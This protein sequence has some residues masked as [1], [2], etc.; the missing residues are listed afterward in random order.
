MIDNNDLKLG[1]LSG[2]KSVILFATERTGSWPVYQILLR[3]YSQKEP[4][5]GLGEFFALGGPS[6]ENRNGQ[7]RVLERRSLTSPEEI[8][9]IWGGGA[10]WPVSI[11]N[12]I[13]Q[14]RLNMLK[15]GNSRY[16]LKVFP[17]HCFPW[18]FES[19]EWICLERRNLFSQ[20]LSY[21]ISNQTHLFYRANG[22][23]IVD[24]S[25]K[26]EY[27]VFCAFQETIWAY[28]V[29]KRKLINRKVAYYEDFCNLG[30]EAFL[31]RI[32]LGD[33]V[34]LKGLVLPQKQNKE[35]KEDAFQNLDE[36]ISWYE[37]SFLNKI[38]PI[39][40]NEVLTC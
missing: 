29:I 10:A 17:H 34:D 14:N 27:A 19:F 8:E 31:S 28:M 25:L 4:I 26:A 36:I 30:T 24:R 40:K 21:L 18:L 2:K 13:M 16:L 3:Y 15:A 38:F 7:I 11:I 6:F 35:R 37:R 33:S 22:L 32:G 20:L 1:T 5:E 9:R 39:S 23:Q 12:V